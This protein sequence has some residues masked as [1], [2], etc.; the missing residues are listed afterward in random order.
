MQI[1][2]KIFLVTTVFNINICYVIVQFICYYIWNIQ[3]NYLPLYCVGNTNLVELSLR[4]VPH[5]RIAV[6]WRSTHLNRDEEIGSSPM[7]LSKN[8]WGT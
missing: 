2:L 6:V 5:P 3:S 8:K 1:K 7:Q 4:N